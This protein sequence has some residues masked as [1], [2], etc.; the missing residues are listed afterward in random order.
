MLDIIEGF[1]F[2]VIK[3]KYITGYTI[4]W[5]F[6]A[7]SVSS[8][9]NQIKHWLPTLKLVRPERY[10][11][12]LGVLWPLQATSV[13]PILLVHIVLRCAI[14]FLLIIIIIFHRR[15]MILSYNLISTASP[16]YS[17]SYFFTVHLYMIPSECCT[18]FWVACSQQNATYLCSWWI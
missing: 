4:V 18:P 2:I 15:G 6:T 7:H 5:W 1:I 16:C 10:R 17:Y 13:F 8:Q 9:Q 14:V 12:D 3:Y 11:L